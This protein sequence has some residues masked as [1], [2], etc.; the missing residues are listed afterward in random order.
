M[1]AVTEPVLSAPPSGRTYVSHREELMLILERDRRQV[2]QETGETVATING[3][4]V[5]FTDH[6]LFVPS[7]GTITGARG[8]KI[9]VQDVIDRLEGRGEPG[10]EDYIEPHGKLGDLAEGFWPLPKIAPALSEEEAQAVVDLAIAGDLD[11]LEA[12]LAAEQGGWARED[13]LELIGSTLDKV[14]AVQQAD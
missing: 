3:K 13:M 6:Q 7:K 14:R 12:L 4:R 2:S 9:P 11:G 10:D 8:E 1:S 5:Q